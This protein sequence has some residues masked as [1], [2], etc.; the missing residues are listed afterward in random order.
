MTHP[1]E[2]KHLTP[3]VEKSAEIIAHAMRHDQVAEHHL[4]YL[5]DK[6]E[7]Y[8]TVKAERDALYGLIMGLEVPFHLPL[9]YSVTVTEFMDKIKT[10]AQTIRGEG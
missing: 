5:C 8:N 1:K 10:Q 9:S 6:A 4:D 7:A 2:A 3:T